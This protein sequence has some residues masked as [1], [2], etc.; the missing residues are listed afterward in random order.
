MADLTVSG[1]FAHQKYTGSNSD[2]RKSKSQGEREDTRRR[3]FTRWINQHLETCDPPVKVHDLFKDIQDGKILMALLEKLSG[4][5]MLY[6]FRSSPHRIF[7]LNNIAK[8]LNFLEDRNVRL[9]NIEASDVADGNPSVVLR[10]IWN[11]IVF[12]HIKKVTGGLHRYF[13]YTASL[14]SSSTVSDVC[15]CYSPISPCDEISNTLPLKRRRAPSTIKYRGRA[16]KTLLLWV[17]KR[18]TKY[19]VDVWDFGKSWRSGLAFLALIKSIEPDLV[20]MRTALSTEPRD[21]VKRAFTIAHENF[22]IRPL[23][24]PEDITVSAPDEQSII[25]YV[26]QFPQHFPNQEEDEISEPCSHYRILEELRDNTFS[27]PCYPEI[28][29]RRK[30]FSETSHGES[31]RLSSTFCKCQEPECC[32]HVLDSSLQQPSISSLHKLVDLKDESRV[33]SSP[34]E[35]FS[36][37][38]GHSFTGRECWSPSNQENLSVGM[39]IDDGM[40]SESSEE[41]IYTLSALDSDEEDAYNYIL[42]LDQEE[43]EK[44]EM[45]NA[46]FEPAANLGLGTAFESVMPLDTTFKSHNGGEWT[47]VGDDDLQMKSCTEAED[48][49]IHSN[50][51]NRLDTEELKLLSFLWILL[52]C[53]LILPQMELCLT[54]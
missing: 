40:F 38:N 13:F 11:I 45:S 28:A 39:E 1:S 35:S 50:G 33:K 52:Y 54:G 36:E 47:F 2:R 6:R 14:S 3:T 5:K 53:V 48:M 44:N 30:C 51:Q 34:R 49:K 4:C 18:T 32:T 8:V 9:L 26:A 17:L 24:D 29:R 19:G 10:L 43:S 41:G 7:R 21:N 12:F 25:I 22:G 23:L 46:S 37:P 42:E 15:N 16:I 31:L 20:D 27:T